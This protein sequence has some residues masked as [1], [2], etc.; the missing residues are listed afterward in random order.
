MTTLPDISL[1]ENPG[2]EFREAILQP[3]AAFNAGKTGPAHPESFALVLRHAA[4]GDII[5]GLWG[6]IVYD[7]LYIELVF[8]PEDLRGQGLGASLLKEAEAFAVKRGCIGVRLDTF[9]FQAPAFYENL[10]YRS[11]GRLENIPKGHDRIYY[12][13][14]LRSEASA[15]AT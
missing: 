13:K 9:S 8:V 10:G 4:R 5:G 3:L 15:S 11:F 14:T 2:A 1:I 12:F 7:W 6:V